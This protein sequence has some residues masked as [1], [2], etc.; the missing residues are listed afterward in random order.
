MLVSTNYT[1]SQ[2]L[3]FKIACAQAFNELNK[4]YTFFDLSYHINSICVNH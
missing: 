1:L 2:S 4:K 3:S